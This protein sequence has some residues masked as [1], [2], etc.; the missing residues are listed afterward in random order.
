MLLNK[1]VANESDN[2]ASESTDQDHDL[3]CEVCLEKK[4]KLIRS[5]FE[6]IPLLPRIRAWVANEKNFNQLYDYRDS[7]RR[8]RKESPSEY[9]DGTYFEDF[10]DG[11]LYKK[12]I[13]MVERLLF[14]GTFSYPS[15]LMDS[16]RLKT[17][18]TTAGQS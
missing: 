6:Y 18:A 12:W 10:V 5:A 13:A 2:Q 8:S 9:S 16:K 11:S 1:S 14:N 3:K 15:R 4:T 17:R 7:L